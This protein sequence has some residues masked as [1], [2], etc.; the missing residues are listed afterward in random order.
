MVRRAPPAVVAR[1]TAVA[2]WW[3]PEVVVWWAPE[4]VVWRA[5]EAVVS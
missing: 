5:R 2:A 4:A 3:F 1:A